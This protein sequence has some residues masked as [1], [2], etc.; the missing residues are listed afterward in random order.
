MNLLAHCI[1]DLMV[2]GDT[3]F[4][5]SLSPLEKEMITELKHLFNLSP[6]ELARFLAQE[7]APTNWWITN[8][9]GVDS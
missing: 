7:K 9:K 3:S 8:S 4:L 1:H 2:H 5:P 6:Q